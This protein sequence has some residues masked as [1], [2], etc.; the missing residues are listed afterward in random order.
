VV[1]SKQERVAELARLVGITV[2]EDERA[3]VGDRLDCLLREMQKLEGLDLADVQPV[4]IFPE[5][6]SDGA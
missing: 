4:S 3:E 6:P 2:R 5:E 1:D